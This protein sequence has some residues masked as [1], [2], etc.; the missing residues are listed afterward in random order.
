MKPKKLQQEIASWL[1]SYLQENSLKTFVVG[2]S[3]GIDSAVTSA[4]CAMTGIPTIAVNLPLNSKQT[5][6]DLSNL[7]LEWLSSEFD[8][9]SRLIGCWD[10][11]QSRRF[12]GGLF[13]KIWRR[14]S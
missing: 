9:V 8:N 14:G 11:K 2:V 7:H 10:R 3:G 6:T 13:Y 1:K 4:L 12:W 5:N